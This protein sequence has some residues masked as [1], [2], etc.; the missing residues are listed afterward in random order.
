M[1]DHRRPKYPAIAATP[2][3]ANSLDSTELVREIVVDGDRPR[4]DIV[5]DRGDTTHRD[6]HEHR[7]A[8]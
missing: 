5:A 4:G 8:E 1:S 3:P 2:L 7:V 6:P